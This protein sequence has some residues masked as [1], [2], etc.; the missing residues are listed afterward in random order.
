MSHIY[1]DPN[2]Q[3]CQHQ[4]KPGFLPILHAVTKY[5]R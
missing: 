1:T 5:P 4:K 2:A 3:V